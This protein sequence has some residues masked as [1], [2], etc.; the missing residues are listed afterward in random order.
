MRPGDHD[1]VEDK[2]AL[3]ADANEGA[4]RHGR[5]GRRVNTSAVGAPHDPFAVQ[6]MVDLLRQRH[7]GAKTA[8]HGAAVL[9]VGISPAQCAGTVPG[10]ERDCFVVEEQHREMPALPLWQA[11]VLALER[12][13][14]P[15][16]AAVEPD[17]V[18]SVME[19]PAI[20]EP[21]ST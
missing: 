1:I 3:V 20:P 12:T 18:G 11:P 7:L 8:R 9:V 5:P 6:L 4:R 19:D 13:D 15:K 10:R 14:D 17:D 2:G 16:V 21:A